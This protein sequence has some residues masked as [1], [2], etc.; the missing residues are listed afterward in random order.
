MPRSNHPILAMGMLI[1][2][3]LVV[4]IIAFERQLPR[5]PHHVSAVNVQHALNAVGAA[6]ALSAVAL[7]LVD[8]VFRATDSARLT[9]WADLAALSVGAWAAFFLALGALDKHNMKGALV[10][11]SIGA[12]LIVVSAIAALMWEMRKS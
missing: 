5:S 6:L 11:G 8:A 12:V 1:I 7:L 2:A 4:G 9:R 3:P 10:G